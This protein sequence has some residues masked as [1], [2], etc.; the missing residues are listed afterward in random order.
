[1]DKKPPIE[2][3]NYV[4]PKKKIKLPKLPR[5]PKLPK[6][7]KNALKK[8]AKAL[9]VS[10][11]ALACAALAFAA[12]W[13]FHPHQ[14]DEWSLIGLPSCTAEGK[15]SAKCFCGNV[16]YRAISATGH[17]E[18]TDLGYA[19]T[20]TEQG[21]TD[22]SHCEICGET[23]LAQKVIYAGS[24][25]LE[26]TVLSGTTCAI[27]GM[28]TCK[29]TELIISNY[30]G[31]YEVTEIGK[32][33]FKDSS[34]LTS[35]TIPDSVT[36][37]NIRA[38]EGCRALAS[39]SLPD[40][41]THIGSY[42]FSDTAY[43]NNAANREGH[44]LYIGNYL[45]DAKTS[46]SGDYSV[47][48]GTL[49]IAAFAFYD[50]QGLTSVKIPDSVKVIGSNAFENCDGLK[51]A[52]IGNGVEDIQYWA[53]YSC[54][55]LKSVTF[56]EGL[57][58][59]GERAFLSCAI[60]KLEIPDSVKSIGFEAFKYCEDLRS[61]TIGKNANDIESQAFAYCSSLTS[62]TVKEGV[63]SVARYCFFSCESLTK[64]TLP[65]SVT[66]VDTCAFVGCDKLA[67]VYYS[68]S[69][70]DWKKIDVSDNKKL[71]ITSRN[72]ATIHY[73]YK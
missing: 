32:S 10:A 64:I 61:V 35:V 38:F 11:A 23:L 56:G 44:V 25:G 26:Y 5:L 60:E 6:I 54:N 12:F 8:A 3:K 51:S 63:T 73:D 15:E 33:A 70:A 34:A 59:I 52:V 39:I 29:D 55:N 2:T 19:A 9:L 41:I 62:V 27:T 28:G 31:G 18:I 43:Y 4:K 72:C 46:I 47:K 36:S 7:S 17:T 45:I 14:Y 1:M 21:L 49:A 30:Y 65:K 22:G 50:C 58:T 42:A 37:V 16:G 40:S 68:G 71:D 57:K 13:L 24:Q 69:K 20:E 67:D 66:F 53:F 48:E